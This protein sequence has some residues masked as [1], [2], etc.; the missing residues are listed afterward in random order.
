ML[1][2]KS[3]RGAHRRGE[4]RCFISMERMKLAEIDPA[5]IRRCFGTRR[6]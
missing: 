1:A 6:R 2:D 4:A 3:R 5:R